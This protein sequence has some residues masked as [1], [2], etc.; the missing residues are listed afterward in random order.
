MHLAKLAA[1]TVIHFAALSAGCFL[2]WLLAFERWLE[3][4]LRRGVGAVIGRTIIWVSAGPYFRIWGLPNEEA[5]SMDAAVA[6]IGSMAVLFSGLLP[7]IGVRI[8]IGVATNDAALK[9]SSY[10]MSF[11]M[12]GVFVLRVLWRRPEER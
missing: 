1:A 7:V 11:P 2:A 8:G 9:A 6:A 4:L 12:I 10:L 5:S 3:P